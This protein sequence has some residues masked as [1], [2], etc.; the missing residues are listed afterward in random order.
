MHR[1][2]VY[3]LLDGNMQQLTHR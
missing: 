1:K 3:T 2:E